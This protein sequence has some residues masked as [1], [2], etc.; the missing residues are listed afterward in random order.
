MNGEQ[1]YN[2]VDGINRMIVDIEGMF[3]GLVYKLH[4]VFRLL[5]IVNIYLVIAVFLGLLAYMIFVRKHTIRTKLNRPTNYF[6]ALILLLLYALLTE[7]P[8][9]LGP[10]TSFNFGLVVMPLA[11]K[12][13]GP[14]LTCAF[15]ML[16][17]GTSFVMHAEE[18]FNVSALLV[19]GISGMIYGWII[20]ANPTSYLRCL[21]AKILVNIV[22]NIV[23]VPMISGK[24]MTAELASDITH[25]IVTN[26]LLAPLQAFAIFVALLIMRRIRN[27]MGEVS[28]DFA[29]K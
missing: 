17:Y 15:G 13:F 2:P 12:L 1:I 22:C 24:L 27:V 21:K 5:S 26:I 16:Q 10:D 14:I 29:R 18:A 23:L 3:G 20:Y 7:A 9:S 6:A 4:P 8:I 28:W 25:K 19:A 11:A